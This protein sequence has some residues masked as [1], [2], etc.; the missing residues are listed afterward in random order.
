MADHT[1]TVLDPFAEPYATR[2]RRAEFAAGLRAMADWVE[3]T[4]FPIHPY[5]FA[6]VFQ[7]GQICISSSWLDDEGFVRRAGSAAKLIGGKVKKNTDYLGDFTLTREF[8]GGVKFTYR[9]LR[10]A[11]CEEVEVEKEVEREIPVDAERAAQLKEQIEAL[12]EEAKALERT[13]VT[14]TEIV[15]EFACPPSLLAAE[16]KR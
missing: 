1:P 14:Q 5:G 4:R 15:R 11:V 6:P 7:D 12:E 3:T 16:Q 8:G 2:E 9:I 10:S 13:R